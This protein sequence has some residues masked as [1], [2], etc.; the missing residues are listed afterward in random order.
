MCSS[1]LQERQAL[2]GRTVAMV[3]ESPPEPLQ[4]DASVAKAAARLSGSAHGVLPVAA[5]DG[6]YLGTLRARSVAEALA[7]HQSVTAGDIT[8]RTQPLRPDTELPAALRA[9]TEAHGAGLPVL[10]EEG[11]PLVGWITY[12]AVLSQL[13][14]RRT[15]SAVS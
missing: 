6:S 9:L 5:E 2:A 14:N 15:G 8:H 12:Q 7:E 10:A 13:G 3:M 4:A 1:D 11:G